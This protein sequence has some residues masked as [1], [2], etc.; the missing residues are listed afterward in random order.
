M[1][2][3]AVLSGLLAECHPMVLR[4]H[5]YVMASEELGSVDARALAGES[6]R[7][8]ER[9]WQTGVMNMELLDA[10]CTRSE[11]LLW[12]REYD[13]CLKLCNCI[14][15]ALSQYKL[16]PMPHLYC[17]MGDA[18]YFT[19]RYQEA[20]ECYLKS[21]KLVEPCNCLVPQE[22]MKDLSSTL[23]KL[24]QWEKAEEWKFKFLD[25]WLPL[26]SHSMHAESVCTCVINIARFYS[27]TGQFEKM[28]SFCEQWKQ[29]HLFS[30]EELH[31]ET[32]LSLLLFACTNLPNCV[33]L[34]DSQI[35]S[36]S[37][38]TVLRLQ[39]EIVNMESRE[40]VLLRL[41]VHTEQLSPQHTEH[42]MAV[43]S[44]QYCLNKMHT[45][46][47]LYRKQL[48][49]QFPNTPGHMIN[50]AT[51]YIRLGDF[52][53]AQIDLFRCQPKEEDKIH[54]CALIAVTHLELNEI[55]AAMHV[56]LQCIEYAQQVSATQW[57]LFK[58]PVQFA[59]MVLAYCYIQLGDKHEAWQWFKQCEV[60]V[61]IFQPTVLKFFYV[62][63][64]TLRHY[65]GACWTSKIPTK[66]WCNVIVVSTPSERNR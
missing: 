5:R 31:H 12:R 53:Q 52:R 39:E 7:C 23:E 28:H 24:G 44:D 62:I 14:D 2:A 15:R 57:I 50:L 8:V 13:N 16:H 55:P 36:L 60:D 51:T 58:A 29:S 45:K 25:S 47:L 4:V 41:L 19:Q 1:Q 43:L 27:R 22:V 42:V 10:L 66:K 59:K 63:R 46:E 33:M 21:Y 38:D 54:W 32:L 65:K 30:N 9:C 34:L 48:A 56:S 6:W 64:T 26:K 40:Q 37:V 61:D 18:Y 3:L 49:I 17:N 20:L 35:N 11:A